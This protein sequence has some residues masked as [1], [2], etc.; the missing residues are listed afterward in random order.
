MILDLFAGAGGWDEGLLFLGCRS[1]VGIEWDRAASQA[2][3]SAGHH[4]LVTDV[5]ALDPTRW[6]GRAS[7]LIASPPCPPWSRAGKRQGLDDIGALLAVLR[8]A[9]A[10]GRVDVP[11]LPW[12]DDRSPLTL[13][14]LRWAL[15]VRPEWVACEQ[16]PDALPLWKA[17]A[18][19][20]AA[21][22][23]RTWTGLLY[24]EE[25]GVP[26]ARR[27]AFL[28]AHRSRAVAAPEPTHTR[29]RPHL[30][31]GGR[32]GLGLEPWVSM[33]E[34]LG[35]GHAEAPSATV[36]AGGTGSGG[37]EPI[38]HLADRIRARG[39]WV[40]QRARA[41]SA[42]PTTDGTRQR[43]IRA[44]TK[45]RVTIPCQPHDWIIG[46]PATTVQADPRIAPPGHRNRAGGE[47]Q[48]PEGT[49]RVEP[50]E[51]GVLQG[52][53]ADYPWTGTLTQQYL[54]VGNAVPPPLAAAVLRQVIS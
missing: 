37:A 25:Y 41:N 28:I 9:A 34:A 2:A 19:A 3:R 16:V 20:L 40:T 45:P 18:A 23:Y 32:D 8:E 50:A 43:V 1:V 26:Q 13:E 10:T 38:A 49:V 7:G 48:F 42:T 4:R 15:A 46:R 35:W 51:A 30:P 44:V 39:A 29:Y 54:Q 14:P 36:T 53:R 12:A 47:S 22:G 6:R 11:A 24:A 17:T 5:S 33:A 27:R 31:G 21:Y 52:F